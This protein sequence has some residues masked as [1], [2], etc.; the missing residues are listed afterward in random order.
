TGM[1]IPAEALPHVFDRFY[2]A[3]RARARKEGGAG[4]GLALVQTIVEANNGTIV[5]ESRVNEGSQFT[6]RLPIGG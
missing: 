1:G 2:R 5:V 6:V 4:L 3:D